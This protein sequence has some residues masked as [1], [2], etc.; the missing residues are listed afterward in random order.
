MKI[1]IHPLSSGYIHLRGDGPCN[2]AQPLVWP[3]SKEELRQHAH[4]EASDEFLSKC[5]QL[6][7]L[8]IPEPAGTVVVTT[9]EAGECV[10]VTRQDSERRI[11]S[12]IWRKG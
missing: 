12:V 11:L 10:S 1:S 2:Y 3:C 9:N 5:E 4:P 6:A 8:L 7:E